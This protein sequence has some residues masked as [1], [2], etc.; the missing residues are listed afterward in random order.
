ERGQD[1]LAAAKFR[2]ETGSKFHQRLDIAADCDRTRTGLQRTA[3]NVE[4]GGFARPVL[5]DQTQAVAELQLKR[6]AAQCPKLVIR[7]LRDWQS[8]RLHDAVPWV[9]V[10]FKHTR[11]VGH[12]DGDV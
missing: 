8:K 6:D 12:R 11:D 7:A 3:D 4:K 5:A 9:A 2:M 10:S 1:I